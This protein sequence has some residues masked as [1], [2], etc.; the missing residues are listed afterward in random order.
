MN[1][2]DFPTFKRPSVEFW[3]VGTPV[4]LSELGKRSVFDTVFRTGVIVESD[5]NTDRDG[6]RVVAV[7]WKQFPKSASGWTLDC[8][9]R[10]H[11]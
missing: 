4:R 9:E 6:K 3:E 1:R 11:E 2:Y 10:I 8:L 5:V 7:K